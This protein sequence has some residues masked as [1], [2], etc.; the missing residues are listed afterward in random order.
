MRRSSDVTLELC[1]EVSVSQV[2]QRGRAY[3]C[4]GAG[5][6]TVVTG[7]VLIPLGATHTG[8]QGC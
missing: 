5:Q 2:R 7:L 1:R 6:T 4:L 8:A 3:C